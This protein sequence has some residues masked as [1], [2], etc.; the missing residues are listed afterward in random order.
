MENRLTKPRKNDALAT[1]TPPSL[2]PC[3][4]VLSLELRVTAKM[5]GM[6]LD[7]QVVEEWTREFE[8]DSPEAVR[9]SFR[10]WRS[11]N[12]MRPTPA[13]IRKLVREWRKQQLDQQERERKQQESQAN[14]ARRANGELV[15]WPEVMEQFRQVLQS[16]AMQKPPL[17]AEKKNELKKRLAEFENKN[18]PSQTT[19][20][21]TN[22]SAQ[23]GSGETRSEESGK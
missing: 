8:N 1:T 6:D 23:A 7:P 19:L 15:G 5:L 14:E 12:E 3:E 17:T 4:A 11:E 18:S 9:W 22:S 16:V 21:G 20:S 10:Q 13:G 2:R